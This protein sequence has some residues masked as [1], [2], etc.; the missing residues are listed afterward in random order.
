MAKNLT[1]SFIQVQWGE[2]GNYTS[3]EAINIKTDNTVN[4]KYDNKTIVLN[5]NWELKSACCEDYDELCILDTTPEYEWQIVINTCDPDKWWK[6]VAKYDWIKPGTP[7][8]KF[9]PDASWN[10]YIAHQIDPFCTSGFSSKTW[11]KT[12]TK[13]SIEVTYVI[14]PTYPD[15]IAEYWYTTDTY[16]ITSRS[17]TEDIFYNVAPIQT[18]DRLSALSRTWYQAALISSSSIDALVLSD[19]VIH[20]PEIEIYPTWSSY[21]SQVPS[22]IWTILYK[23]ATGRSLTSYDQFTDDVKKV[24]NDKYEIY[25]RWITRSGSYYQEPAAWIYDKELWKF[26]HI[27]AEQPGAGI[28]WGIIEIKQWTFDADVYT[29]GWDL[30]LCILESDYTLISGSK[31]E[32]F[33]LYRNEK[34]IWTFFYEN[35]WQ[36]A[37]SWKLNTRTKTTGTTS[38]A[39]WSWLY[40]VK[41]N[42]W[43]NI[44][45]SWLLASTNVSSALDELA[46]KYNS[47]ETNFWK[48]QTKVS[49]LEARVTAL[50]ALHA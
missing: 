7:R 33:Y 15:M 45:Y 19:M 46:R 21:K 5:D 40:W 47:L 26:T 38:E 6:Y 49:Q 25:G 32:T 18:N 27:I 3:G 31:T 35:I 2:G 12:E 13:K 14:N 1:D 44:W 43:A 17:L 23:L 37:T 10:W 24:I 50:E 48:I 16:D 20:D 22:Y 4:V 8:V 41:Y 28:K 36:G 42:E 34:L 30:T 11:Y 39:I 29:D 9:T